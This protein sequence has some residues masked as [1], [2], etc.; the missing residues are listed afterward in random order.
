MKK[1]VISGMVV[2][3]ALAMI[4]MLTGTEPAPAVA[5]AVSVTETEETVKIDVTEAMETTEAIAFATEPTITEPQAETTEEVTE[6]MEPITETKAIKM[7]EAPV[8]SANEPTE[9]EKIESAETSA[10]SLS[11]NEVE[12][13][14]ESEIETEPETESETEPTVNYNDY[15]TAAYVWDY[16]DSYGYS[17][18]AKA[19][20]LGNMMAEVGGQTLSLN[21]T[22]YSSDGS[23]YGLCQWSAYY[24]PSVQ[25]ASLEEQMRFLVD[26]METQFTESGYSVSKFQNSADCQSAALT[27]AKAYERCHSGSYSVRQSNAL[28]AYN[29]F[30]K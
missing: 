9:M 6:A 7:T 13:E 5:E 23:Y 12:E 8:E 14:T 29:Y 25:G 1:Y 4:F 17:D 15:P 11:V 21:A 16:L 18:H 22:R 26:T 2:A 30:V 28:E 20:I 27:F 3:F 10:V 24:F 19:G